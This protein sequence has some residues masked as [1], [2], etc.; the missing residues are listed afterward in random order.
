MIGFGGILI[1]VGV[2][3]SLTNADYLHIEMF[4]NIGTDFL[5]YL[6]AASESTV[7]AVSFSFAYFIPF[8]WMIYAGILGIG[9]LNAPKWRPG[10]IMVIVW[11]AAVII[12]AGAA[13]GVIANTAGG[14]TV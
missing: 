1:G 7:F 5:P 14:V 3:A 11:I 2:I 8:I 9:N 10:L 13:M 4:S 12:L 6:N